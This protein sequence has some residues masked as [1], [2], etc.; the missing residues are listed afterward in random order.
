M[1]A[2]GGA[3]GSLGRCGLSAG[4]THALR[5]LF[6]RHDADHSG[7]IEEGELLPLLV[8]LG[9]LSAASADGGGDEADELLL[10]M[11][12]MEMDT[13]DDGKL[14]FD[15]LCSWWA[16]SGRGAPPKRQDLANAQALSRR[17]LQGALEG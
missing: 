12:M 9:V 13:N 4:D 7:F 10:E 1:N 6:A 17:L 2:C 5:S 8:D 3:G 14:S 11:Q 16:A 15:E